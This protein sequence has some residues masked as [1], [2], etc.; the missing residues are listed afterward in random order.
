ML[1]DLTIDGGRLSPKERSLLAALVLRAGNVVTPPELADAV[2]GD[3]PPSTWPKQVQAFVVRIR[4]ALGSTSVATTRGGYRLRVDPDSIDAVR[5]ERLI[6]SAGIH[7]ANGD[8]VRAIDVLERAASLWSGVP[9][10][11]LGEW[12]AAIAEAE[13]LEEIR[14]SA[15]EDLQAAR[16]ECRRAPGRRPGRGAPGQGRAP[17]RTAVGDSRHGALP[18]RPTG[19]RPRHTAERTRAAGRRAR[20]RTR[21]RA[22]GARVGDPAPGCLARRATGAAAH[23]ARLPLSRPAAVRHGRCRGVLRARRRHPGRAGPA[24]PG[25]RSSPSPGHPGAGNPRWCWRASSRRSGLAVTPWSSSARGRRR[26]PDSE[27][28]SPVEATPTSS[29]S[30]SSRNCS[31]PV[32]RM[33]TS[34]S[35]PR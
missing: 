19:R 26:S 27:T 14:T 25:H 1:G 15:E 4:R 2:W 21:C 6:E 7:R 16:L 3:E 20:H 30:T 32:S 29:S 31:I 33:R 34:P 18:E 35:S 12:P 24:R 11:D 23:G 10:S 13:R 5:Y 22:R 8:P 9:Y 28:H 17:A